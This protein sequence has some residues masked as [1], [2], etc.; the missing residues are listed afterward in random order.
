MSIKKFFIL[1]IFSIHFI[2]LGQPGLNA[3][4]VAGD[5][6]VGAPTH[7]SYIPLCG[8][9]VDDSTFHSQIIYPE[10]FLSNLV[11]KQIDSLAFYF[12]QIPHWDIIYSLKMG[13]TTDTCFTSSFVTTPLTTVYTGSGWIRS[14]GLLFHFDQ[15]FVYNEG[16]LL[17]DF[18]IVTPGQWSGATFAGETYPAA[19]R[20][21]YS[22]VNGVRNFI[23][24]TTFWYNPDYSGND[25]V[26]VS[27]YEDLSV[28]LYPNP[29]SRI[30][31]MTNMESRRIDCINIFNV[32][33]KLVK[34]IK[35]SGNIMDVS[36]LLQ[37]IYFIH[38]HT[39]DNIVTKKIVKM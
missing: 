11:G 29:T 3:W 19:S 1:I 10:R 22:N 39:G 33:G 2:A 25:T 37:G 14:I 20:Y 8:W 13:I 23:P 24:M 18:T 4:T 5:G 36:D 27:D 15:P 31:Y 16:N 12:V 21:E 32:E 7:D 6:T 26:A 30:L 9:Y 28:E 38:I 35:P 17:M 34:T